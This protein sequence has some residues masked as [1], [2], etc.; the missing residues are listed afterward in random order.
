MEFSFSYLGLL[1]L[2]MLM[3]PNLLWT[4]HQPAGY[5]Q[6]VARENRILGILERIGEVLVCV[7]LLVSPGLIIRPWSSWSWWLAASF[8]L[9]LL[10]EVWWIRY[11][12]SPKTMQDFNGPYLGIP[13]PGA[14]LPVAAFFLLAV[15]A[16]DPWLALAVLI[17]A[18]GH[19]GIHWIHWQEVKE[20]QR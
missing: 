9:M 13:V 5:A 18:I 8:L 3:V 15:Y 6:Y 14:S 2:L 1:Y 4:R 11:F 19:I 10:Y 17:L 7:L 12:R 20:S 16:K